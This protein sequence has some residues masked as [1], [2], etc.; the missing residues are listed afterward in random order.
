MQ[1]L[2][3]PS[4]PILIN[5]HKEKIFNEYKI[6]SG[7]VDTERFFEKVDYDLIA[8][9]DRNLAYRKFAEKI[10][11]EIQETH[12]LSKTQEFFSIVEKIENPNYK[13]RVLLKAFELFSKDSKLQWISLSIAKEQKECRDNYLYQLI[14]ECRKT[15]GKDIALAAAQEISHPQRKAKYMA[16]IQYQKNFFK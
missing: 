11:K 3:Q 9:G 13:D 15:K 8:A 10:I 7:N 14:E 6:E 5:F 4:K 1:I 2:V 16:Q 12:S